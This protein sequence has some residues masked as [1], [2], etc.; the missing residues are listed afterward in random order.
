[1]GH[2]QKIETMLE[3]DIEAAHFVAIEHVKTVTKASKTKVKQVKS[4][5]YQ[6]KSLTSNPP[7]IDKYAQYEGPDNFMN[8]EA[9]PVVTPKP[10]KVSTHYQLYP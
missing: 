8:M 2:K 5:V 10:T 9:K 6:A 3:G 4:H 7:V 1:M